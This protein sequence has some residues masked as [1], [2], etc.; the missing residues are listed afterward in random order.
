MIAFIL[1]TQLV[2]PLTLL[3]WLAFWPS[4]SIWGLA[5][6]FL[7][8]ATFLFA[9]ARVAQWAVPVW[10]LPYVYGGLWLAAVMALLFRGRLGELPLLPQFVWE[11][12]GLALSVVLL[13]LGIWYGVQAVTGR[14][15]PQVAIVDIVNPFG[16]RRYL[17]GHGG[18]NALVNGHMKTLNASVE[19]FRPW[20][21]QSGLALLLWRAISSLP[22]PFARRRWGSGSRAMNA[23]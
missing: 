18:S 6:Q 7:A 14:R 1:L 16:P 15:L 2:L 3:A 11:W 23:A 10:W 21:G 8:T 19:R 4:S 9:L 20:R 13:G 12:A 17:V 5:L 22:V